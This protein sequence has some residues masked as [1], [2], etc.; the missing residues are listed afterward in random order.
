MR[1][2]KFAILLVLAMAVVCLAFA[3][4]K[5]GGEDTKPTEAPVVT[6]APKPTD[7]PTEEGPTAEPT[8][9]PTA[10]PTATPHPDPWQGNNLLE[11]PCFYED[12]SYGWPSGWQAGIAQEVD[13]SLSHTDDGSGAL[14]MECDAGGVNQHTATSVTLEGGETYYVSYWVCTKGIN[15]KGCIQASFGDAS[16]FHLFVPAS[17]QPSGD[18]PWTFSEGTF[19]PETDGEYRLE[20]RIWGGIGIVYYDDVYVG[21]V[22]T[23]DLVGT[24]PPPVETPKPEVQVIAEDDPRLGVNLIENGDFKEEMEVGW[25]LGWG[26]GDYLG[27]D[28]EASHT[29]DGSGSLCFIHSEETL[30]RRE[31]SVQLE[32]YVPYKLSAWIKTDGVTTPSCA[33]I[34][35]DNTEAKICAAEETADWTYFEYVFVP[36]FTAGYNVAIR[37]WGSD[38][39]ARFDDVRIEVTRDPVTIPPEPTEEPAE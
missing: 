25:D 8:P 36:E 34:G 16:G 39:E 20:L 6:D 18:I 10:K 7:A 14:L 26:E 30:A 29:D 28:M 21:K 5:T 15:T 17:T 13:F 11:D 27:V 33:H 38:G 4:C 35:V 3:A 1:K 12:L 24:P 9:T 32:A 37:L 31:Q 23:A 2:T 22:P 19:T